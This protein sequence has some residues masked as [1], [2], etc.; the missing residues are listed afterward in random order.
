[1]SYTR[2]CVRVFFYAETMTPF[3]QCSIYWVSSNADVQPPFARLYS[4]GEAQVRAAMDP[5]CMLSSL[6]VAGRCHAYAFFVLLPL[7]CIRI[8]DFLDD[9]VEC[10]RSTAV[11][12]CTDGP[13]HVSGWKHILLGAYSFFLTCGMR[14]YH[15][16]GLVW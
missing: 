1:M 6:C 5:W 3:I 10:T 14:S 15:V 2:C 7:D 16:I 8:H 9:G 4:H 12:E 13:D 11:T